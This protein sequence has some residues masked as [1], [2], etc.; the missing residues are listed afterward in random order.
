MIAT[1]PAIITIDGAAY[2]AELASVESTHLGYED[3][4]IGT[5]ILTFTGPGWRQANEPRGLSDYDKET[6]RQRGTAYGFDVVLRVI[7]VLGVDAWEKIAGKRVYVLRVDGRGPIVGIANPDKP[8][9]HLL[10]KPHA[11]SFSTTWPN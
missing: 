7:E 10:F 9:R 11:E 6:K 1:Q 2:Q 5:A 3:H 8:E 4:G